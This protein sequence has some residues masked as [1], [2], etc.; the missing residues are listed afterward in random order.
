MPWNII[1]QIFYDFI[2]RVT[3]GA[4]TLIIGLLVYLGPAKA[5]NA[6]LI[7]SSKQNIL[8]FG[9][10][11]VGILI[12]YVLGFMFS[13]LWGS[14]FKPFHERWTSKTEAKFK[15]TK[16]ALEQLKNTGVPH[17]MIEKLELL[18][19]E[20]KGEDEFLNV[21]K[22]HIGEEQFLPY[23][24]VILKYTMQQRN[25][26]QAA[27]RYHNKIRDAVGMEHVSFIKEDELPP[28][29]IMH[30]HLRLL[31]EAEGYRLL[32]L[33]AERDMGRA[34][35]IGFFLLA[36]LNIGYWFSEAR[37]FA[38]DRMLLEIFLFF[39]IW[40]FWRQS[41]KFENYYIHGTCTQWLLTICP[42]KLRQAVSQ[43]KD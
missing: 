30:D 36:V 10:S 19:N 29:H 40:A 24:N 37:L 1:P 34:L 6:V 16:N 3:P 5:I 22:K 41:A 2:A 14:L 17:A 12:S 39:A 43:E 8:S 28:V 31:S 42:V 27:I 23:Q 15:L 4:V 38:I 11:I 35:S 9:I 7:T 32:K 25:P 26:I 18:N 20:F 13:E 21:M 33:R